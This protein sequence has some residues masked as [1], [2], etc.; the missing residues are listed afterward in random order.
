MQLMFIQLLAGLAPSAEREK[1][2]REPVGVWKNV[3]KTDFERTD[4]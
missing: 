4:Q 1:E 2:A 3:E